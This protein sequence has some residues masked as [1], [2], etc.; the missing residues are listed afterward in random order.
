LKIAIIGYGRMGKFFAKLFNNDE[1]EI[2]VFDQNNAM[3][4]PAPQGVE[5]MR[6]LNDLKKIDPD[7]VIN[8]VTLSETVNIFRQCTYVVNDKTVLCDIT[9]IKGDELIQFYNENP[10]P[11]VSMHPFFG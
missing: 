2:F 6:S 3:L 5:T 10:N 8:A 4:D 7:L 9:S 1:N 11:F